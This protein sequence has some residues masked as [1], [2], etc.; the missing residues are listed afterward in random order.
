MQHIVI[1]SGF[2]YQMVIITTQNA[3]QI[4]GYL[5]SHLPDKKIIHLHTSLVKKAF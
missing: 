3:I 5:F 2:A 4:T 1:A